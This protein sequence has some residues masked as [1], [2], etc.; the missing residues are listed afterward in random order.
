[1]STNAETDVEF[2]DFSELKRTDFEALLNAE[3]AVDLNFL[4][5]SLDGKPLPRAEAYPSDASVNLKL[6]E[7]NPREALSPATRQ[8]PFELLFLGSHDTPLFSD[9]HVM[10]H[11]IL[12]RFCVMLTSVNASPGVNPEQHSEGRFYEAV[13][14]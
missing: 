8:D 12:G 4:G 7:V 3:F 9:V 6:I 5:L 2:V 1:M 14:G 13:V 11:E 10:S